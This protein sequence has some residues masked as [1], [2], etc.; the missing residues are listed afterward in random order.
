[1][2]LPFLSRFPSRFVAW[3]LPYSFRSENWNW[4][5]IHLWLQILPFSATSPQNYPY[6]L[7]PGLYFLL[8]CF[9]FVVV[10][11]FTLPHFH[12]IFSKRK[13]KPF[14]DTEST[15]QVLN[16]A[17]NSKPV[18]LYSLALRHQQTRRKLIHFTL[19]SAWQFTTTYPGYFNL[20]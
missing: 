20:I 18:D 9:P 11:K 1:M 4:A 5:L 13:R 7:L 17:S 3:Y 15:K 6:R 10:A 2:K 19:A 14:I 12:S 8:N 16:P